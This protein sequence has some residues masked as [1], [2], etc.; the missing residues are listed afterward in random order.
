MPQTDQHGSQSVTDLVEQPAHAFDLSQHHEP[1]NDA[2]VWQS[3][4]YGLLKPV[5][6]IY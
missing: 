6:L 5:H 3:R 4:G 2:H 1:V